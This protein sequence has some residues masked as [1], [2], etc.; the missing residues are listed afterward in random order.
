MMLDAARRNSG[1]PAPHSPTLGAVND[2]GTCVVRV[3]SL[4][5]DGSWL[6]VLSG[7]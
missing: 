7:R 4:I 5:F 2:D 1:V 3:P 6:P